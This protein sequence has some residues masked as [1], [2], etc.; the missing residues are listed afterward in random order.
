M[1]DVR[2]I[3]KIAK[4]KLKLTIFYARLLLIPLFLLSALI[5]VKSQIIHADGVVGDSVIMAT[6]DCKST[7]GILYR[8]DSTVD[9]NYADDAIRKD[10]LQICPTTRW[11]NVSI[12]FKLFDLAAGDTLFVFDG[13][14]DSVRTKKLSILKGKASGAGVSNAFSGWTNA[15]CDPMRNPTGCLTFVFETNGDR[16]KGAGWE[17]WVTCNKRDIAIKAPQFGNHEA[18]CTPTEPAPVA[19]VPI[20]A[21]LIEGTCTLGNK[22]I[23]VTISNLQTNQNCIVETVT[24][25]NAIPSSP[26]K[27]APG[28][29]RVIHALEADTIKQDTQYFQVGSP[30]LVCNDEINIALNPF[31]RSSINIDG[32]LEGDT[33]QGAGVSHH[34]IIKNDSGRVVQEGRDIMFDSLLLGGVCGSTGWTA[35]VVRTFRYASSTAL[36]KPDSIQMSCEVD[37]NVKDETDPIF[38]RDTARTDTLVACKRSLISEKILSPPIA[39]DNCFDTLKPS[40][41]IIDTKLKY[42][43]CEYPRVYY[44]KWEVSDS[45]GNSPAPIIDTIRMI[46]PTQFSKPQSITTDC[47]KEANGLLPLVSRARVRPGLRTGKMENGV[48]SPKA[49][50]R[51]SLDSSICG[52]FAAIIDSTEIEGICG[53]KSAYLLWAAVDWCQSDKNPIFIDSQKIS[54]IDETPPVLDT[55]GLV[56]LEQIRTGANEEAVYEVGLKNCELVVEEV[57]IP[58]LPKITDNCAE[59]DQLSVRVKEFQRFADSTWVKVA[60]DLADFLK[61]DSIIT[62]SLVA[63]TF[64][65]CYAGLDVCSKKESQ[66]YSHF[67]LKRRDVFQPPTIICRD[68]YHVSLENNG[69][70]KLHLQDFVLRGATSCDIPI[71]TLL[72]KRKNSLV[73][74]TTLLANCKDIGNPF[75]VEV[76]IRDSIGLHNTCWSKVIIEDK[77]I[78][79]CEALRDTTLSCKEVHAGMFGVGTDLNGNGEM[80]DA[81]WK[82]LDSENAELGALLELYNQ[83]FGNPKYVC[84]DNLKDCNSLIIEQEYQLIESTCGTQSIRRRYRAKDIQ[85]NLSEWQI[86]HII[87]EYEPDWVFNFPMNLLVSCQD[88]LPAALKLANIV[89]AGACDVFALNV[90]EQE[91]TAS[92]G[93]CKTVARTYE[94]INWCVYEPGLPAFKIP[95]NAE[96]IADFKVSEI[97]AKTGRFTYTQI[98]KLKVD[99]APQLSILPMNTCI[100][101]IGDEAPYGQEDKQLGAPPYECDTL[102]TFAVEALNC[103]GHPIT[104]VEYDLKE[105]DVLVV[106]KGKGSSFEYIVSPNK[107]YEVTFWAYD[108]CGNSNEISDT[109]IFKDCTAPN[110]YLVDGLS[111]TLGQ[112]ES[113][114]VWAADVDLGSW[115]NCTPKDKLD[116]RMDLGPPAALTLAEI[117]SLSSSVK[118]TC[119]NVG[120]Q[121]VSIYV[122]DE[123]GNVSVAATTLNVTSHAN[124][125]N[126]ANEVQLLSLAGSIHTE[127]GE[128]IKEVNI[129][130]VGEKETIYTETNS[131]GRFEFKVAPANYH[132]IPKKDINPLSGVSTYDLILISKHIL[133]TELLKSPFQLIAADINQSGTISTYDLVQLR[134]LILNVIDDFPENESWRFVNKEY[135]F[136]TLDPLNEPFSEFKILALQ[137][138]ENSVIDFIGIKIGDVSGDQFTSNFQKGTARNNINYLPIE[139]EDRYVEAGQIIQ[140][141]FRLPEI[142]KVEGVQFM[143]DF[144]ALELHKSTVGVLKENNFH[145]SS[146]QLFASWNGVNTKEDK[147]FSASFLVK[148]SAWLKE[149]IQLNPKRLNAE[150]YQNDGQIVDLE[151]K[152]VS[153]TNFE[154]TKLYQ[155]S[156][157]PFKEIT[158]IEFN[159]SSPDKMTFTINDINGKLIYEK[160]SSFPKGSNSILLNNAELKIPAGLYYYQL[161]GK[162]FE[163]TKKM[164]IVE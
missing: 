160:T 56:S 108:D 152:F 132:L 103:L 13:S 8:D 115:D 65:V 53:Q 54:F 55:T 49:T 93:I 86:Q 16:K 101:G 139:I 60:N 120:H 151:L 90:T 50:D 128:K 157:N 163:A 116:L 40:F 113:V 154:S 7:T 106:K 162:A 142:N 57:K 84:F 69:I 61:Q 146:S 63:D 144:A 23:K 85:G 153:S 126:A 125:C 158:K 124:Q 164:V 30:T 82:K 35:T 64:R 1:L 27:L 129:Q 123:A 145:H 92:G 21:A 11:E 74:D 150:A 104:K 119:N 62:D 80:E 141:D 137:K 73:W 70:A 75:E 22:N 19:N 122:I 72:F 38:D 97:T 156:P 110:V 109:F 42:D 47:T 59:Q 147:L 31:C 98:I 34:I 9:G 51:L 44:I 48:F 127:K 41:T 14:I 94:L 77:I 4:Q 3:P 39:I 17:A 67:L 46:R 148:K 117:K 20:I 76:L 81:E 140:V 66:I 96:G 161:K 71:D 102:K 89:K 100:Y 37:I 43:V 32:L 118:L 159:L 18:E 130:L 121:E 155:N 143:L 10:T 2:K 29:Y 79:N 88:S 111:L 112:D 26:I 45:C 107:K 133:G 87:I 15:S 91:F 5:S 95:T 12:N 131:D 105:A 58:S 138:E 33:C 99:E 134:Q 136:K 78:P 24:A 25:G 135:E 36:C 114:L 6:L 149:L 28:S 83:T 52:Y 68:A